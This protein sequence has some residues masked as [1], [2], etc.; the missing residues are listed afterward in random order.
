MSRFSRSKKQKNEFITSAEEYYKDQ[1]GDERAIV[2]S[3][4]D[5][6]I[7]QKLASFGAI[8]V[9]KSSTYRMQYEFDLPTEHTDDVYQKITLALE[10]N[11]EI[12]IDAELIEAFPLFLH[13]MV[14]QEYKGK[15]FDS[16]EGMS[17]SNFL[18]LRTNNEKLAQKI[19][20]TPEVSMAYMGLLDHVKILSI[21]NKTLSARL[22]NL[23]KLK[24]FFQLMTQIVKISL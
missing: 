13:A 5:E 1:Y 8:R 18:T 22:T 11:K 24:D 17:V 23:D 19:L 10:N 2:L 16:Y 7:I 21:N 3:N 14:K 4:E 6:T 12:N 15:V 9:R 20:D